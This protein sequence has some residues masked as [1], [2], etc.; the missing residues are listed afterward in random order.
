MD[1]KAAGNEAGFSLL[2]VMVG[3]CIL[4]IG[5][6]PLGM[7]MVYAYR[8]DRATTERKAALAFAASQIERVRGMT[9][10]TVA[11]RPR[12]NNAIPADAMGAGGYLPETPAIWGSANVGTTPITGRVG[13]RQDLD[14]D[15]DE[16]LFGLHFYRQAV[17]VSGLRIPV[18]ANM[19]NGNNV[20]ISDPRLDPFNPATGMGDRIA[21]VL[22]RDT[23]ATTGLVEGSGYWVTVRVTW[24]GERG[25]T[26]EVRMSTFVS[27]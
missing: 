23:D 15:G 22:L 17:N 26:E 21:Q 9:F 12:I 5:L 10:K 18:T 4:I 25:G 13:F 3:M 6:M 11:T 8:L 24:M 19:A 16:D 27:R 14:G 2:E 1:R 20:T 7:S